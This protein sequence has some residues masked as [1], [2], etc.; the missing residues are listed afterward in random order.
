MK[1]RTAK[2]RLKK[3]FPDLYAELYEGIPHKN[4]SSTKK[5]NLSPGDFYNII[6]ASFYKKIP[7]H[8]SLPKKISDIHGP[9]AV[10]GSSQEGHG[11]FSNIPYPIR[12]EVFGNITLYE[13][14]SVL[15]DWNRP[16]SRKVA[17]YLGFEGLSNQQFALKHREVRQKYVNK[18]LDFI[19]SS[20]ENPEEFIDISEVYGHLSLGFESLPKKERDFLSHVPLELFVLGLILGTAMDDYRFRRETVNFFSGKNFFG[21]SLSIG[22]GES[23]L[24]DIKKLN[25][26][27][28]TISMLSDVNNSFSERDINRLINE[29]VII[30]GLNQQVITEYNIDRV[31]WLYI[32][33]GGGS[34]SKAAGTSD[35]SS[36]IVASRIGGVHVPFV[37]RLL[38]NL[39]TLIK[40]AYD[41]TQKEYLP[42][43]KNALKHDTFRRLYSGRSYG[44]G[45]DVVLASLF[46]NDKTRVIAE[47]IFNSNVIFNFIALIAKTNSSR[48]VTPTRVYENIFPF[49]I[50]MRR[51]H[52]RHPELTELYIDETTIVS[53]K[54]Y[55]KYSLYSTMVKDAF[56][57]LVALG[58][59]QPVY[60][61]IPIDYRPEITLSIMFQ[62][63]NVF[64]EAVKK[65]YIPQVKS[66]SLK[67]YPFKPS[68]IEEIL[69]TG[70][71]DLELSIY[72]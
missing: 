72:K 9:V 46:L 14:T 54:K 11:P 41:F 16:E 15:N 49:S 68:Q 5:S 42:I 71:Y 13:I 64:E 7:P 22:G 27:G 62:R 10:A 20:L 24:V 45:D 43:I 35:T 51:N 47:K 3:D 37:I 57:N 31:E 55:D 66:F 17:K 28:Y 1:V 23:Y 34:F 12:R 56:F 33:N 70:F 53:D 40:G 50:G 32:R 44:E 8:S 26:L 39:D 36:F 61:D 38:D 60:G 59:K 69:Y 52:M 18:T 25:E 19:V 29:G 58:Q 63:E 6:A 48:I 21:G 2:K 65:G 4:S 30:H 67:D